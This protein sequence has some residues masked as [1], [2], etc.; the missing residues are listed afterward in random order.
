MVQQ[1]KDQ[2]TPC[3]SGSM[4][5]KLFHD[6]FKFHIEAIALLSAVLPLTSS[7]SFS[8]CFDIK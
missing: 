6:D 4:I 5:K 1:L 7:I 3:F 8:C 2:M